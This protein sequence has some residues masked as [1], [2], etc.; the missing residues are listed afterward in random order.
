MKFTLSWLKEHLDTVASVEE[1]A[2]GLTRVGIEVEAIH[3]PAEALR[4]FRVAKVLTAERHPQADKLQVLTV[5]TGDGQ[6]LQVVCGAPNARAGLVGVF[7]GPGTYVPGSDLTLKKAAI[8]GV[9]SNGMMCSSRELQL[10]DDHDGI[11]ELPADAPI[12]QSFADYAQLDDPVFDVA[13]TPNRPD[14]M[15]VNGIARDLAAIGL[16]SETGK[17]IGGAPVAGTFAP[18]VGVTIAPDSGCRA[19]WRRQV[20]GVKNGPSPDWLQ[21]RLKAIGL[22]PISALVDITN[23]FSVDQARPLH[24]YDVKKLD[25]DIIVRRGRGG[26]RFM[27]LND[28]EYG[29]TPGDCVI[30]DSS[31]TIGLGGVIGGDGTGVDEDTTDV[32]LECAWF[33]PDSIARTGQRHMINTD[34]RSRFERGIDPAMMAVAIEGATQ[35]ILDLCGGE[36][37]EP[38]MVKADTAEGNPFADHIVSYRPARLASLAG[39]DLPDAEQMAILARLGFTEV[40][41]G[42]IRVPSWRPDIDGEADLVEEIARING[43]DRIPSTPLDREPGVARPTATRSQRI[44]RKVRRA[45]AARGLNEAVTWS[46]ISA[47]DAEAVGGA[48]WTLANPISE[49]MKVMRPSLLPGLA[50]AARHNLDRGASSARLFELGRRYLRDGEHRTLGL[51]LAGERGQRNWQAGKAKALDAFDGKAEVLALLEAA[52]APVANLQSVANAGAHW[53]PGRSASLGLGPKT[54]LA[55]FGEVHPAVVKALDAPPGLVA[56]EI[57]LDSIPEARAGSRARPAFAPPALQ[58]VSRDFA[59]IVPAGLSAGELVR[60]IRASDKAAISEARLFDRFDAPDGL[61]LAVEVIMQ[62]IDKTFT[63]QDIAAIA[64][65]VIAAAEKLGARLRS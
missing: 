59:F 8:R 13:V 18:S 25:G 41:P 4:P 43:Y 57:Y 48:E 37:S 16:G 63:E 24:V 33:E 30:A 54:I 27:A 62:P 40:A 22:R 11:V 49:D 42:Q 50:A 2:D 64:A 32:L 21:Q 47:S 14:C 28:K 38:A 56:A 46:F 45:A 20:R 55:R 12:G 9:E 29:V 65:K 36:A 3:N 17:A 60:S 39:V 6:P 26:E 61:S 44:E 7:G 5:D 51:V 31:G 1:I 15:G 23:F 34:A 52:G 19:F 35:M 53:H 58:S 10:G